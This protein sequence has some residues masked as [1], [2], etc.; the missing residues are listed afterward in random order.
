MSH[1]QP[2]VVI[3]GGGF[4]GLRALYRLRSLR[5]RVDLFLV[6][7]RSTSLARPSLPEVAFAGKSVEHSRFP[8]AGPVTRS[9]A[10]FI[11][12]SVDRVEGAERRVVFENGDVLAYDFLL[13]ALGAQ[14]DYDAVDG[15]RSFG[16]SLCDD[17]EAPRLAKAMEEFKGGP[18]VVGSAKSVWG[19]RVEVPRLAAPCE[20]PV[21]E[22]MF[23]VDHDLRRRGLRD[24]SRINV[25]SPGAI[26]FED[27]GE[28]VHA[29]VGALMNECDI[30]VATNK[31]LRRVG[32]GDVTFEDGTTWESALSIVLPPYTGN[33][34]VKRSE[35]LGDE[36]GFVPTD[37]TMRHL[38]FDNIYAAG[39]GTSLAMPKLGHIAVMQADIA[40]ASLARDLTGEGSIPQHRPEIFCI[41]NR[42][43]EEA[44]LIYSD[45]LFGGSIDL[46]VDGPLAHLMKWGFDEYYFH[47]AGHLPPDLATSGLEFV[48]EKLKS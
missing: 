27:V 47:S 19:T 39:D 22:V 32:D 33:A 6:D 5:E 2:K 10:T 43:G 17:T 35:G 40:A 4:A 9:G 11:N 45:T 14:K 48:L 23:M 3:L 36:M 37:T 41:A 29:S 42:G 31:V 38:D 21:A 1:G 18:V 25:F 8:L 13:L 12:Q 20:G 24:Q 34:V 15:F 16:Y 7:P 30:D 28:R 46:T 44:T 26:F